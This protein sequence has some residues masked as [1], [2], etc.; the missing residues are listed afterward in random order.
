[1]KN[2][3]FEVVF[4]NGGGTTLQVGER[5]Y[6]HH[7]DTPEQAAQDVK[8]LIATGTT[9]GWEGNEPESRI[10]YD[11]ET[12]LNGGYFWVASSAIRSAMKLGK[13]EGSFGRNFT[14]FFKALGIKTL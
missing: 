12:E 7:Y 2:L 9:D 3:A 1:M 14:N 5:G 8:V 11:L 13:I 10:E 6:V 4:D